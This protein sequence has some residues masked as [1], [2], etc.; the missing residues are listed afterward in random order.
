MTAR[1]IDATMSAP[2]RSTFSLCA[3]A[4][5][6][7][8]SVSVWV[9]LRHGLH[10]PAGPTASLPNSSA[11]SLATF[12]TEHPTR[13]IRHG[14]PPEIWRDDIP[15]L[16]SG[17]KQVIYRSTGGLAL[18]AWL[19]DPFPASSGI[20][21]PAIVYCHGGF[22]FGASDWEA[23]RPFRDA[24]F[25]VITPML[26]GE[27]GNPGDFECFFGEVDDAIAA[28]RFVACLPGIDPARVFI[29][30]H[31]AGG[32]LATL[33]AMMPDTP[34]AMSAPIGAE[35]DVSELIELGGPRY[36][37]LI[38]FDPNSSG[39]VRSRSAEWFAPS[40]RKPIR[41]FQ[42]TDDGDGQQQQHF[43]ALAQSA[44]RD[45]SV[46]FVAGNHF[47][48]ET[49]AIPKIVSLFLSYRPPKANR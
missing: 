17:C 32:T 44:G 8:A 3:I 41:L 26:R 20:G 42:G 23:T 40:L 34:F 31:S 9:N 16:A 14:P 2:R 13:L 47:Q 43:V 33:S 19:S 46:T 49:S 4:L 10:E 29:S 36:G 38:V 11:V 18:K 30:G 39:E 22:W 15:E 35:L 45:A 28:G 25:V 7:G 27:D 48:S 21:R 6:V 12:R 37:P 5:A 24:G 1:R